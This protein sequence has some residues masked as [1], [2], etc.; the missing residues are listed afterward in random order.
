MISWKYYFLEF[1][2]KERINVIMVPFKK[3]STQILKRIT[4][5]FFNR[6]YIKHILLV[7]FIALIIGILF[8]IPIARSTTV[9][10]TTIKYTKPPVEEMDTEGY[11][12]EGQPE[13]A[14]AEAEQP[15]LEET[16]ADS[17]QPAQE[18]APAEP[19]TPAVE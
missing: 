6:Q 5:K 16:P 9:N 2:I 19:E 14:P 13:E 10:D 17:G 12:G 1:S 18:E 7:T 11:N 3:K 8:S 15:V 4:S